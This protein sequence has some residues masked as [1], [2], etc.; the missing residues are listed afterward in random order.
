MIY[1]QTRHVSKPTCETHTHIDET[2]PRPNFSGHPAQSVAGENQRRPRNL[3]AVQKSWNATTRSYSKRHTQRR[4]KQEARDQTAKCI[5][6]FEARAQCMK[7]TK[8]KTR[9]KRPNYRVYLEFRSSCPMHE[10][11]QENNP[12]CPNATFGLQRLPITTSTPP[13][14]HKN[15]HIVDIVH[16]IR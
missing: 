1:C 14:G 4:K 9:G 15:G 7:E 10:R 2:R 6:N 12:T 8:R 11:K 5:W 16:E 3:D 13:L